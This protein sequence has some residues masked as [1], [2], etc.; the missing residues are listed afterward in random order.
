MAC[1]IAGRLALENTPLCDESSR[2][3]PFS[4]LE[5]LLRRRLT[6]DDDGEIFRGNTSGNGCLQ[7]A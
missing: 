5:T 1:L 4:Q 2:Q 6:G 7:Y 3:S